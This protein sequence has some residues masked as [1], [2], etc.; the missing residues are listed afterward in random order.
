GA[1]TKLTT[2][3]ERA[4]DQGEDAADNADAL[5]RIFDEVDRVE[6]R[7]QLGDRQPSL[8]VKALRGKRELYPVERVAEEQE[9]SQ[10]DAAQHPDGRPLP[11]FAPFRF[12]TVDHAASPVSVR[13]TS[14][15][16]RSTARN[17][18]TLMPAPTS[19]SL[20]SAARSG[21][22]ESRSVPSTAV[23]AAAPSM[24]SSCRR[25]AST[26]VTR[27]TIADS[28]RN[29]CTVPCATSLPLRM[30]AT[31]SL[32]CWT[33]LS[34]WLESMTVRL[35][36]PSRRIRERIS[37]TPWG[38][39]PLVGSSRIISSGSLINAAATARRCFIPIE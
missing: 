23:T 38:S 33:S 28:P 1:P 25:A 9:C 4:Q 21:S 10:H 2:D 19:A 30:I 8:P 6:R 37:T 3:D 13:K 12:E 24:R 31:R 16:V 32:I 27:T 18:L 15:R 14:S 11:Q 36:L 35:P 26:G 5:Q 39:R 29:S 34:K 20:M 22:T 7:L 17:S